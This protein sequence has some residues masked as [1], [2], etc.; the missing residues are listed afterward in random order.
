M[1]IYSN[2]KGKMTFTGVKDNGIISFTHAGHR[3]SVIVKEKNYTLYKDEIK[4]KRNSKVTNYMIKC[5][6]SKIRV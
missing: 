2:L 3:Y 6:E 5:Y 4:M 1:N